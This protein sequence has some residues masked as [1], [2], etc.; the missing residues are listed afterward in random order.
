MGLFKKKAAPE[1][2]SAP[3]PRD[4][5]TLYPDFFAAPLVAAGKPVTENNLMALAE[6]ATR[7]LV[8]NAQFVFDK[9][10]DPASKDRFL[11]TFDDDR[12]DAEWLATTPDRMIDFM[13]AYPRCHSLLRDFVDR[14]MPETMAGVCAKFP[15]PDLPADLWGA[16]S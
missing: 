15:G 9:L 16:K 4:I 14:G 7:N 1:P 2:P 6:L 11:R 8:L 10:G 13:W 3:G 5:P 12:T